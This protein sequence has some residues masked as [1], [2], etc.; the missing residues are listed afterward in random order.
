VP[1]LPRIEHLV[2][3]SDGM[4]AGN[5]QGNVLDDWLHSQFLYAKGDFN[6]L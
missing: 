1:I 6:G 2:A 5:E 3:A 4:P